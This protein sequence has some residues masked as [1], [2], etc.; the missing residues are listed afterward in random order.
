M[1]R[2]HPERDLVEQLLKSN[3]RRKAHDIAAEA[4]LTATM[5]NEK[6]VAYVRQVK[7]AMKKAGALPEDKYKYASDEERLEDINRLFDLRQ[8][9]MSKKAAHSMLLLNCYYRFRSKDDKGPANVCK[10]F[11]YVIYLPYNIY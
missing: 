5:G 2:K 4:G 7:K 3:R 9:T 1:G 10:V 8:G 11:F 6:A